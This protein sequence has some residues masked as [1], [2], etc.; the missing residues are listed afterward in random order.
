MNF[1]DTLWLK[2]GMVCLTLAS[3]LSAQACSDDETTSAATPEKSAAL[4]TRA[5][6]TDQN[7]LVTINIPAD[8]LT[9][10]GSRIQRGFVFLSAA[11]GALLTSAEYQNG[12]TLELT[13]DNFDGDEFYLTEVIV[14]GSDYVTAQ[15]YANIERGSTWVVTD[16]SVENNTT[17]A[18]DASLRLIQSAPNNL[19][20][21]HSS[22]SATSVYSGPTQMES[23]ALAKSPASLYITREDLGTDVPL[24]YNIVSNITLNTTN[25][26]NLAAVNKPLTQYTTTVPT[27]ANRFY[28][29][30]KGYP[31][32]GNY[33]EG[34]IVSQRSGSAGTTF[35]TYY[36]GTGFPTYHATLEYDGPGFYLLKGST[37]PVITPDKPQYNASFAVA[38]NQVTYTATGNIDWIAVSWWVEDTEWSFTL[39]TGQDLVIPQLEIPAILSAWTFPAIQQTPG[40]YDV[41]EFASITGYDGLKTY[42]RNSS[43]GFRF[44]TDTHETYT[45]MGVTLAPQNERVATAGRKH[46]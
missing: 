14:N 2:R 43:K 33:A 11:D 38:N 32:L 40:Y 4:S 35:N 30:V 12:I 3:L 1:K 15:T 25:T 20:H 6:V 27:D 5:N 22:T 28:L 29:D 7:T 44:S 18:G 10:T 37:A 46:Q 19:Y 36:P 34:I 16:R 24:A 42:I 23:I 17:Y 13:A 39:P 9:T 41:Y 26:I 31:V 8:Q 45:Q 21:I